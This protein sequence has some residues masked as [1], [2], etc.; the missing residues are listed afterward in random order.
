MVK[1]S[2]LAVQKYGIFA[3][4]QKAVKQKQL[5]LNYL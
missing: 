3:V 1:C 4:T 5:N 2:L